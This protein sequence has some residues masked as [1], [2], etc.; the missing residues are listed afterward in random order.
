M[1][2]LLLDSHAVLWYDTEP[3][4]IPSR[5]LRLIRQ[6]QGPVYV[7]ALS[8]YELCWKFY[9][10]RLPQAEALA[11]DFSMCC[12]SYDFTVL[13]VTVE[14][15]VIATSLDWKHPDPFDRII[16]A[17]AIRYNCKLVTAD[18]AFRALKREL[19]VAWGK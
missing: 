4:R 1:T 3:D 10:G 6:S 18:S 11:T 8:V 7:S 12:R 15:I 19:S 2:P 14:D 9:Q 5:V 17:Q 16:A 13:P